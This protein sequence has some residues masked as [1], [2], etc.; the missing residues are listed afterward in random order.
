[1]FITTLLDRQAEAVVAEAYPSVFIHRLTYAPRGPVAIVMLL[2]L[3][4]VVDNMGYTATLVI[5]VLFEVATGERLPNDT[6]GTVALVGT[7][8][9]VEALLMH[10]MTRCI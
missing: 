3:V 2:D 10:H 1:M 7:V 8:L 9:Y 5:L 4:V 6:T